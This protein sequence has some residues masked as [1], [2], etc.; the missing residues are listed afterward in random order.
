MGR[1]R[2][3]PSFPALMQVGRI[4]LLLMQSGFR[5][6]MP[7]IAKRSGIK[8]ETTRLCIRYFEDAGVI[9]AFNVMHRIANGLRRRVANLYA[10]PWFV[11][12]SNLR[13]PRKVAERVAGFVAFAAEALGLKERPVWLNTSPLREP[14][15]FT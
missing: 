14:A 13:L 8:K 5:E 10:S 9:G 2:G 3:D 11:I 7:D 1:K 12:G 6:S 15:G 4:L